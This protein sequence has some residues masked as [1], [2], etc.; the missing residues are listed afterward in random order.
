MFDVLFLLTITSGFLKSLDDQTS[1]G[2][3]EF[4]GG[5]TVSDGKLNAKTKTFVFK[6]S[7]SDIVLNL[8]GG[9]T[10]RTNLLGKS[11]TSSFTTNG[12]DVDCM[13]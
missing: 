4:D 11:V 1:S 10:E 3:F 7:L 5:N 6:G 13:V 8:L 2:R 12:T 9:N